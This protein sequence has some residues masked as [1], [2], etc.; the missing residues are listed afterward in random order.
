MGTSLKRK[1]PRY[2]VSLRLLDSY[3]VYLT[4]KQ[5]NPY[6]LGHLMGIESKVGSKVKGITQV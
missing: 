1:S 6:K 2:Y 3:Q 5:M 4:G